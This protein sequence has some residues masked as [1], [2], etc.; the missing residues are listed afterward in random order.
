MTTPVSTARAKRIDPRGARFGAGV[1]SAVLLAVLILEPSAPALFLLGWQVL[2]FAIGAF[3]GPAAGPYSALY[4]AGLLPRLGPP[5]ETED[6]APPR[7][8][9]GVGL[10]F[11]AVGL[12]GFLTGLE[13]LGVV[14]TALALAA[15]LLNAVFGLCLGC[16]MYVLG[17]RLLRPN[18]RAS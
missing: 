7:F 13:A 12:V 18:V 9:Q 17:V 3:R 1:T 5:A 11:A 16:K 8:A 6:A 4:R 10:A 14:A 15:A 2:V